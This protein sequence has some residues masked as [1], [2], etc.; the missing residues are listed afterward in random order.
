MVLHLEDFYFRRV[1]LFMSR[2]DHGLP[3]MDR[4]S[5]IWAQELGKSEEERKAEMD[6]LEKRI[7]KED[8]WRPGSKNRGAPSGAEVSH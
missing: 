7:Q 5:R 8:A 6:R 3:W 4:L 1:P 2:R